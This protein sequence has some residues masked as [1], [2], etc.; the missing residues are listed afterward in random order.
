MTEKHRKQVWIAAVAVFVLFCTFVGYYVGVPMVRLAKEPER[1]RL[2]VDQ[3]GVWGKLLFIAMV[4]LQ[5]IVALIPGEPLELAAGYAFGAVEGTLLSM[6]G[7]LA[8]SWI[9]FALVRRFGVRL[10]EVFFSGRDIGQMGFLKST[11]KTKVIV[12]LLMLIPG[13]PKDFLSYFAGMTQLTAAQ[14]LAIVAVA[15]IPSL[16]TS[17]VTGAAA[18]EQNYLLAAIMLLVTL[19]ISG[20]GLLYY[21]KLCRQQNEIPFEEDERLAG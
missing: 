12:F 11:K 3:F 2:W 13:T 4:I 7:I 9:V 19:T 17:T 8:G 16:V 18:G 6:A 15:R 21:R 10:V 5:V 20:A 1:F 14:W